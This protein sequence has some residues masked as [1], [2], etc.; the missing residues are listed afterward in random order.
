M[1]GFLMADQRPIPI[2]SKPGIQR[3]GTRFASDSYTDGLWVRWQRARPRK[4]AGFR[5]IYDAVQ[6][7]ARGINSHP[8]NNELYTHIGTQSYLRQI[9]LDVNTYLIAGV[10]DRT[11]AALATSADNMWQFDQMYDATSGFTGGPTYLLA[12]AA[13]NALDIGSDVDTTLYYGD[14]TATTV[15][16]PV[17]DGGA[18]PI[19]VSG[20]VVCLYPYTFAF[21][22]DG[23]L[24]QS[25]ANKPTDFHNAGSNAFRATAKKIVRGM[26][27]RGGSGNAPSGL[28]WSLDTIIRAGFVGGTTVFS[29]DSLSNQSGILSSMSVIEHDGLYYWIGLGRFMVF[30]GLVAELPN[31]MNLN[32]FFDNLNWPYRNKTFAF[33][34]PKYGEIWWCF[35]KAPSTEPN[36]AVIYNITEKAWYDTE[37]PN[38]GR[39]AAENPAS[40]RF[41]L[42]AGTEADVDT[43]YYRLWQHEVGT[44][45]VS[46]SPLVSKAVRSYFTT[47]ELSLLGSDQAQS[48][49]LSVATV[50]PDFIQSG[51][52]TMTLS[53]RANARA[54]DY[55][56]TPLTIVETP[57]TPDEQVI[58][59]KFSQ[60]M[61]RFTVESNVAGGDYQ[62]GKSMA[63]VQPSD[64][65][66]LGKV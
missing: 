19:Q 52:L 21:G 3:D 39:S 7:I 54:A 65:R 66:I 35:P 49:G 17:L 50:E 64:E 6:G 23:Y 28:F 51:S 11:P 40:Y 45:E 10:H 26:P 48:R 41:P 12:H 9:L 15:L 34:V 16:S 5:Q 63:H 20:G 53:G 22:S 30:N 62:A 56:A 27:L 31:A 29:Y 55:E 2:L 36:W 8:A 60:R 47:H 46:G 4:M 13:P 61:V 59:F 42:M 25:V 37:L 14:A 58:N 38:G 44:D 24:L 18:S 57:T 43:G 1:G 33:K 32:F